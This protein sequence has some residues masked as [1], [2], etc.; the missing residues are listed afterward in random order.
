VRFLLLRIVIFINWI[1]CKFP[2]LFKHKV[3]FGG[4]SY[5]NRFCSLFTKLLRTQKFSLFCCFFTCCL[6][7]SHILFINFDL[8]S[9]LTIKWFIH[10]VNINI[11]TK[12]QIC[13]STFC[14]QNFSPELY[15][16]SYVVGCFYKGFISYFRGLFIFSFYWLLAFFNRILSYKFFYC[17]FKS[18]FFKCSLL[19]TAF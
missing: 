8:S 19:L 1:G 17:L 18:M 15:H 2:I 12:D 16:L 7:A 4:Q 9:R 10:F 11:E 5:H 3:Y 13:H 14:S 6:C